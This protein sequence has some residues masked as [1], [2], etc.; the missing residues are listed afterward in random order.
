V[1]REVSFYQQVYNRNSQALGS[2]DPSLQSRY[3]QLRRS[4]CTINKAIADVNAR[5]Q[6]QATL[7][8]LWAAQDGWDGEDLAAQNSL[9]DNNWLLECESKY[10][11]VKLY[12]LTN[13]PL[14]YQVNWLRACAQM[15]R[16]E[17]ELPWMEQ[18][19]VWTTLY[20]MHQRDRWYG[21]LVNLHNQG[22]S[23]NGHEA[24]CEQMITQWEE[25]GRLA[26]FQFRK[27]N[28]NFPDTWTPIITP[29]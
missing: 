3:P 10:Y 27:A 17:E 25:Y 22:L 1:E 5:G 13:A 11:I 20:F 16:W 9:L 24:Y 12:N 23:Q 19:M 8:W 29:H 26:A 7:P 18:E 2:L 6:S 21:Q 28:P 4:D 15:E 14:V